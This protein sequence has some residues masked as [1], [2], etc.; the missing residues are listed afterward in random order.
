MLCWYVPVG[1]LIFFCLCYMNLMHEKQIDNQQ[2]DTQIRT[3]KKT[4]G[5]LSAYDCKQCEQGD[6][7]EVEDS[8]MLE[9]DK[10]CREVSRYLSTYSH[11]SYLQHSSID[12]QYVYVYMYLL[13]DI[14]SVSLLLENGDCW[15]AT[16]LEARI[17]QIT[18][19]IIV[20][21]EGQGHVESGKMK[22]MPCNLV[23]TV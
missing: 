7:W 8:I 13:I 4:Q 6:K 21:G 20:M 10:M 12:V 16:Q 17:S 1:Y 22:A 9:A 5:K 18:E 14:S 19:E 23:S 2:I 15:L 3:W 11:I